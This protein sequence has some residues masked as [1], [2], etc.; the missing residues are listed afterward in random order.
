DGTKVLYYSHRDEA[1]LW[2]VGI[3]GSEETRLTD[4]L[5]VEMWADPAPNGRDI[6]Y[7]RAKDP[8][9]KVYGS[10]II[11]QSLGADRRV[12]QFSKE[13]FSPVWSPDGSEV[14]FLRVA[15]GRADLWAMPAAGGEARR[16]TT[17]GIMFTGYD[18]LPSNRIQA[19]YQWS[20][21]GRSVIF[22][23]A[24]DRVP[25]VWRAPLDGTGAVP[26]TSNTELGD[27]FFNPLVSPNGDS[28]AFL[29]LKL[30]GK[31]SSAVKKW[32][33]WIND[34]QGMRLVLAS[35]D[36]LDLLGWSASGREVFVQS[37]L[38]ANSVSLEEAEVEVHEISAAT[39]AAS[40]VRRLHA[41]YPKSM[42]LSPDRR[43]LAYVKRAS[44][45]DSINIV[46]L[47][48]ANDRTILKS[49][50]QRVYFASLAWSRDG[51]SIYF[52]REA[53]WQIISVMGSLK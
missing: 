14:A 4:D 7:Q 21:D 12:S 40:L 41:A 51:S 32:S 17:D 26:I 36:V 46:S 33:V 3:D 8:T 45:L 9:R 2:K 49:N 13:G 47:S 20:L 34:S 24:K 35:D 23:S 19:D 27:L 5:A 6:V 11:L 28:V 31:G 1:D 25:N 16:L 53:N 30:P 38:G 15:N 37:T 50:D 44:S 18:F 10:E 42:R 22:C 48:G 29:R 39:G 43:S 52:G